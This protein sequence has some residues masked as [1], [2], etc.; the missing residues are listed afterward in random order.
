MPLMVPCAN[1]GPRPYLEFWCSGELPEG[2][3]PGE[4]GGSEDSDADYARTW[5]RRNLAGRQTERWFHHAGCRRWITVQRDTRTNLI[6]G[7]P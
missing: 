3:H 4:A 5:L 2:R 7:A 6:D 1:C